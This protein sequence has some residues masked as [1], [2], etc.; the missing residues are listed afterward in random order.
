MILSSRSRR[1][2]V[3]FAARHEVEK[4][5]V[6]LLRAGAADLVVT[7]LHFGEA[8]DRGQDARA[9]PAAGAVLFPID[10]Q[11]VARDE[12]TPVGLRQQIVKCIS[13]GLRAHTGEQLHVAIE[14]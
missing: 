7:A 5:I 1:F 4:L 9:L 6:S 8:C 2:S 12:T 3:S 13:A 14:Q 10:A 11:L